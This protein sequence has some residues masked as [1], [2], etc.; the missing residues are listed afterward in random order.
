MENKKTVVGETRRIIR[1]L[2]YARKT[3][4]AYIYW[5]RSFLRFNQMRSPREMG[6]GE[7]REYLSHL[8]IQKNVAASTQNQAL[9]ALL[10]LYQKVLQIK[11]PH[12]GDIERAKKPKKIPV[13]FNPDEALA[14]IGQLS[15]DTRMICSILYGAGLRLTEALRLRVKDLDFQRMQVHVHD[16]KHGKD[17]LTVLPGAIVEDLRRQIDLVR[18]IHRQDLGDG[19]GEVELPFALARKYP[20]AGRDLAWQYL[21]P[22]K[23]RCVWNGRVRRHH[24]HESTI[25]RQVKAALRRAGIHKHAGP[26]TFR[27]SFATHLLQNG[28]DIRTVQEL[29]GH[30]DVKTTMIYTHVLNNGG[31]TVRSPLDRQ[32]DN[33]ISISA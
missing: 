13:V 14:V 16:A 20:T 11:L 19:Y 26:H 25:Q 8:A 5:I 28:Y 29:L 2:H 22:S 31:L 9:N 7:I 12:I 33:I 23:D 17:R 10:F 30:K 18:S 6:A 1:L 4:E 21:F 27:H 15:G 3:E 24:V 32:T